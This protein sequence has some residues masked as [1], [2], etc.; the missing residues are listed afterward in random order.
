ML[1]TAHAVSFLAVPNN[2]FGDFQTPR[3]LAAM[4]V[5]ALPRRRWAQIIEPT[6]GTGNILTEA[7][8]RFP[9]VDAVG[10]EIQPAHVAAARAQGL[11]VVAA[12]FFTYP[13]EEVQSL[14]API[15]EGLCAMSNPR[16][17]G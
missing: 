14:I 6:C 7:V 5:A 15:E 12:D 2:E 9:G 8:A 17:E 11:R 1:L 13:L 10:I 3:A 16:S 4:V